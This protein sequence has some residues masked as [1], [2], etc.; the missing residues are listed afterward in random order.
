MVGFQGEGIAIR[1]EELHY[2]REHIGAAQK[3]EIQRRRLQC[4]QQGVARPPQEPISSTTRQALRNNLFEK[5]SNNVFE[6]FNVKHF[7]GNKLIEFS[8]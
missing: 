5:N 6:T 4:S 3:G 8:I 2:H 7:E 1:P